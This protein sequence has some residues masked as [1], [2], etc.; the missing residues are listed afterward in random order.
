MRAIAVFSAVLLC[1]WA[2]PLHVQGEKAVDRSMYALGGFTHQVTTSSPDAQMWFDRG[3]ALCYAFNH[4]EA[5]YCFEEATKADPGCAMAHWGIAYAS[6]PN[7]NNTEMDE[8]AVER[9]W[10]NVKRADELRANANATETALIDAMLARYAMPAP[11]D[12][13]D[14]NLA[15]ANA[16]REVAKSHPDDPDVVALFAEAMMIL[17]P[18]NQFDKEGNPAPETPEIVATLEGGL[19]RWP[20]HPALCH[21]Y[22]HTMEASPDPSVALPAANRLREAMPGAGHLVH[23]PAH[24]DVLVGDYGNS[25]IANQKAIEA[26]RNYLRERGPMNFYTLYRVHNYHFVVYSAMFDGQSELAMSAASEVAEQ[27]PPEMLEEMPEFLEAF[28]PTTYHV[29]VRFGRW[30]DILAQPA[31]PEN[32]YLTTAVHHYARALAYASTNRVAD[33]VSEKEAFDKASAA[34]PDSYLLFNNTS[35]DILSVAEAMLAGEIAYRQG[36][37]D[38]AFALLRK[39]VE[40]DDALNYDE[41]WGWMQPVRHSLGALLLEQG[42]VE[43]AEQVYVADLERHPKN[44]WALHGLAECLERQGQTERAAAVRASFN[45]ACARSDV[46]IKASCYCRLSA[47]ED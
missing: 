4:E 1:V 39:G 14:L 26:D 34:V 9:A 30:E 33:A 8:A 28:V 20:S 44:A 10:K 18:W 27:I 2:V 16:M 13:S 23:M 11:E 41:P 5:I 37:Y 38:G 31:P 21:F 35:R 36:D 25:I 15:Y 32:Y 3:L 45:E 19:E 7:I 17:R 46:G 40:L 12:R 47:M 29:L 42:R 22:I 43:E 24:I 6:G